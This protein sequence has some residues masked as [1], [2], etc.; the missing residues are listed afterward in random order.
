M[1]FEPLRTANIIVDRSKKVQ[2]EYK[3]HYH[4]I[5][6]FERYTLQNGKYDKV[7]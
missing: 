5:L 1:S 4:I 6:E 2:G 7:S 3:R